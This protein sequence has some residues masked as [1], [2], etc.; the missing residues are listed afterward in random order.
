[1]RKV[2]EM[3]R[4]MEKKNLTREASMLT[5]DEI[6]NHLS[7]FEMT[8]AECDVINSAALMYLLSK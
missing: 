3:L 7:A 5:S 2:E 1:M 8:D 6:W 4:F